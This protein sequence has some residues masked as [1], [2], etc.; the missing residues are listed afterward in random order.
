MKKYYVPRSSQTQPERYKGLPSELYV[1]P[2]THILLDNASL[3]AKMMAIAFVLLVITG[4]AQHV[5]AY[6]FDFVSTMKW[7]LLALGILAV[8]FHF[9]RPKQRR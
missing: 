7:Y 3:V 1:P 4:H 8:I 6:I 5:I 9:Y 2:T